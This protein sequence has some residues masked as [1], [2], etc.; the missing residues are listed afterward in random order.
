M[1]IDKKFDEKIEIITELVRQA[2][3]DVEKGSSNK[4]IQQL[5]TII[6]ELE[7]MK[8]IKN[9][10]LYIPS[11]PR[12]I[13]D[14]WDYNDSLGIELMNLFEIYRKNILKLLNQNK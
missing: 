10:N 12:F 3:Y 8:N 14:S 7:Q 1:M 2:I 6:K 4:I 13:I 11:F 5:E 9:A